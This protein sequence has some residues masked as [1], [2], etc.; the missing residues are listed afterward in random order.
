ME[1]DVEYQVRTELLFNQRVVRC[2]ADRPRSLWQLFD[3]SAKARPNGEAILWEPEGGLTYAELQSH[4]ERFSSSLCDLG[5]IRGDRIAT[6][7]SNRP[8]YIITAL[9]VWRIGAILVPM[10]TRLQKNEIEHILNHSGARMLVTEEDL[11]NNLPDRAAVPSVE[12]I[13]LADGDATSENHI[14]FA[15]LLGGRA[16]LSD[17]DVGEEDVAAILYTSGTTGVP[18]GVVLAHVNMIHSTM[19]FQNVW[20][21]PAGAR[22]M[23]AIPGSNVTGLVTII[24]TMLSFGGCIVLMPLFKAA[25]FLRIAEKRRINHTFMVPAQYKLLM[26]QPSIAS[27]DLSSWKLGSTGGAP[28]PAAFINEL[29][30]KIPNLQISDGYGATELASPAIIRPPS[31]TKDHPDSIGLPVKCADVVIMG[32]DG[33]EVPT[34]E[35]G[36]LWIRGPMVCREYWLNEPA[37]RESFIDGYWRSGDLASRS[38][39][40]LIRLHDRK[41]DIVNRGGYKIYSAEVESILALHPD[42]AE[43]AIIPKPDNVLGERVHAVIFRRNGEVSGEELR[44][45]AAEQL[46]DYKV[47]EGFTLLSEPLPRNSNGKIIKR[48]LRDELFGNDPAT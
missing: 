39:D 12:Q 17:H 32:E 33:V 29:L 26:M 30:E 43:V 16:E 11:I 41:K 8:E 2:F 15:D 35:V 18:K 48:V 23:L 5:L 24:L 40:G 19:H 13:L 27:C 36:E 4:A 34:G 42:V 22:S 45:F 1:S 21:L 47:P 44:A 14:K 10:D 46:A 25:E 7:V 38:E 9:A 20:R 6:L 37:T 3:S 31:L 28:M